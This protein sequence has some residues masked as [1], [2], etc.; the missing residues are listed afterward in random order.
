MKK[1]RKI[2]VTAWSKRPGMPH[3]YIYIY[4]YIHCIQRAEYLKPSEG[5]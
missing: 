1:K 3:I 2:R 4:I 5:K